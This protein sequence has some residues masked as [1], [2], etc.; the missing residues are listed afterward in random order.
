M[1]PRLTHDTCAHVFSPAPC[2]ACSVRGTEPA[3]A[4]RPFCQKQVTGL[5][6][7]T[8]RCSQRGRSSDCGCCAALAPRAL[9]A[10]RA[11]HRAKTHFGLLTWK[12][13]P[14]SR[15]RSHGSV[16]RQ[17]RRQRSFAMAALLT[18]SLLRQALAGCPSGGRRTSPAAR[19]GQPLPHKGVSLGRRQRY[20][21]PA[22]ASLEAITGVIDSVLGETWGKRSRAT[23]LVS[24]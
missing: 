4:G 21:E 16:R 23:P 1:T 24:G 15:W 18:T 17:K 3:E 12:V 9:P 14:V 13:V 2:S 8:G 5:T 19:T 11:D 7:Q 6:P 22:R 20:A 10:D